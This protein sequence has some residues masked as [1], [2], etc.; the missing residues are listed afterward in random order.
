VEDCHLLQISHP[1]LQL[2]YE[3]IPLWRKFIQAVIQQV[4]YFTEQIL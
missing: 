1:D 2:L 3:Q 4:H